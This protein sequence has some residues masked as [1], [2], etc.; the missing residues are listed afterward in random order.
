MSDFAATGSPPLPVSIPKQLGLGFIETCGQQ[1][2]CF[3][4][5]QNPSN[6]QNRQRQKTAPE[7]TTL[8]P[9]GTGG[10][11]GWEGGDGGEGRRAVSAALSGGDSISVSSSSFQCVTAP[12]EQ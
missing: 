10:L 9:G 11:D 8:T 2:L 12:G 4:F 1:H 3:E 5:Q 7:S 6:Q